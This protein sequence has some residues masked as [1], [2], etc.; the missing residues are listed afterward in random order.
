MRGFLFIFTYKMTIE[1]I[2]NIA[3]PILQRHKVTKAAIFGS[4]ADGTFK[5]KSDVDILVELDDSYSLLDFI[6]IKLD[7]EEALHRSV[8]LVEYRAVKP[9]L[10]KYILENPIPIYG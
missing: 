6:G 7:L 5:G 2:K 9:A 8:D 3:T 1:Q 4:M 10:K